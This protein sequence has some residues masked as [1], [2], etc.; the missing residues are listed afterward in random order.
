MQAGLA[1][2]PREIIRDSSK[3]LQVAIHVVCFFSFPRSAWERTACRSAALDAER[4]EM[5]FFVV[6][7]MKRSGIPEIEG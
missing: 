5:T 6:S 7:G 1:I 3:N 4:P 2:A